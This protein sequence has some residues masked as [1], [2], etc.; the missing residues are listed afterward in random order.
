M[1]GPV[2]LLSGSRGGD[3]QRNRLSNPGP[4]Y[5]CGFSGSPLPD[6]SQRSC[7]QCQPCAAAL[8][9]RL[10]E[11]GISAGA[12]SCRAPP[13]AAGCPGL[14]PVVSSSAF[15]QCCGH[16]RTACLLPTALLPS[17]SAAHAWCPHA[18]ADLGGGRFLLWQRGNGG[19]ANPI[20]PF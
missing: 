14:P 10:K 17:T 20:P 8:G 18:R 13:P 16:P 12:A 19:K 4:G 2:A 7:R 15:C 11:P 9:L 5:L 3:G 1:P 6:F